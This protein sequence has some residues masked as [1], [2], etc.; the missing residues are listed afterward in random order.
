M[1]N[2]LKDRSR[3]TEKTGLL[4]EPSGGLPEGMLSKLEK[5]LPDSS[6]KGQDFLGDVVI[7]ELGK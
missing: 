3:S 6:P 1:L 5:Q 4:I 2:L 7:G